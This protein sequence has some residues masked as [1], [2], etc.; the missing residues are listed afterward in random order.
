MKATN[1]IKKGLLV[2][3]LVVMNV[4]KQLA[5]SQFCFPNTPRLI[6]E[7]DSA[8]FGQACSAS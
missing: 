2:A 8:L 1:N 4:G 7:L 6:T 5:D 3:Y